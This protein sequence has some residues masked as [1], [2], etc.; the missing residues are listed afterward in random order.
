MYGQ[1]AT[2]L[3]QV[4]GSLSLPDFISLLV[5]HLIITSE[6]DRRRRRRSIHFVRII[7]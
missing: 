4:A 7:I 6:S 5:C 1:L 2:L 3:L